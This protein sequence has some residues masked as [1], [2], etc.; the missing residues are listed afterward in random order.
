[1]K[2]FKQGDIVVSEVRDYEGK[3]DMLLEVLWVQ[4]DCYTYGNTAYHV[5]VIMGNPQ[6]EPK[7]MVLDHPEYTNSLRPA[8]DDDIIA[9]LDKHIEWAVETRKREQAQIKITSDDVR[10]LTERASYFDKIYDNRDDIRE[11]IKFM[12]NLGYSNTS[13]YIAREVLIPIKLDLEKAG[14]RVWADDDNLVELEW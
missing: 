3:Y 8:T 7:K 5:I 12:A 1:M 4:P 2:E 11:H 9:A 14:F 13:F 6:L 10:A